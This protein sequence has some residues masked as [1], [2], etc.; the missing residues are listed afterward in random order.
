MKEALMIVNALSNKLTKDEIEQI[1]SID[2]IKL[3]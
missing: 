1:N 2:Y 3:S